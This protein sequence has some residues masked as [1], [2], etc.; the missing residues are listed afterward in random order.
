M[1]EWK[2]SE[3]SLQLSAFSLSAGIPRT[4]IPTD[5]PVGV[6]QWNKQEKK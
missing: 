1:D 4:G 2:L 6:M 5:K 3:I